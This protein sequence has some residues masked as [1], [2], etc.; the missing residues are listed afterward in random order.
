M[1]N[2][3]SNCENGMKGNNCERG[4]ITVEAVL[5]LVPFIMVIM[6][7]I[8]FINIFMVH[9]KLQYA[10][11]Q[12]GSELSAYTY[13]YE[14]LGIRSGDKALGA[15]I[16]RE[17][18]EIDD[19]IEK[20]TT[21]LGQLESLNSSVNNVGSGGVSNLGNELNSVVTETENTIQSGQSAVEAGVN[22]VSDP[23]DLLRNLVYFGIEKSEEALKSWFLSTVSSY[24][25]PRYLDASFSPSNPM[26]AD[27]Y[28]KAAGV[29]DGV[30]GLDFGNSELFMDD[31]YR[32]IDIVVE[33]DLEITFFKLFFKDPTITVVQRC[34]VPAWL[35]GDGVHYGK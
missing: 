26:T 25:V 35:D 3:G 11:Y 16:D 1:G 24:L 20:T 15:D 27:E 32:M 5:S 30:E 28:L 2:K 10:M 9:N 34:A 8:S 33:Y 12:A 29:V 21:F 31:E 19:T 4:M 23:Q 18:E 7:I 14:A 22:L 13:F 6:G 17:T